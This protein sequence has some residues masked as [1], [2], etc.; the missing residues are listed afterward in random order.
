M[1][2]SNFE[3]GTVTPWGSASGWRPV[4]LANS[5]NMHVI[6][7]GPS[8]NAQSGEW[9]LRANTREG[10]GSVAIDGSFGIGAFTVITVLAWVRALGPSMN[11]VLNI[12]DLNPA[13]DD[14]FI[15]GKNPIST[16]TPFEAGPNWTLISNVFQVGT[17]YPSTNIRI[18]FYLST[19]NANL[20]IDSVSMFFGQ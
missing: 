5:V 7:N 19:I 2:S 3:N 12:W 10:G 15:S 16:S 1:I 20:D 8:G 18:E 17:T 13:P 6:Q 4:N 14:N 11:G 9:F